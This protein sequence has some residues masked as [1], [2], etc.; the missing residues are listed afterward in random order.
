[1]LVLGG[2]RQREQRSL[3]EMPAPLGEVLGADIDEVLES[4]PL[5][6]YGRFMSLSEAELGRGPAWMMPGDPQWEE[7]LTPVVSQ[8]EALARLRSAGLEDHLDIPASGI[9]E[10]ALDILIERKKTE[11][12]RQSIW[13]RA[14][15]GLGPALARLAAGLGAS[16]LDPVNIGLGFVPVISG[17]RYAAWLAG[18]SAA[19]RFGVRAG[20]GVVEGAAGAALIEPM[21]MLSKAREQADYGL[22]ES[23]MNI[24]FGGL[25]GGGLH[26]IGG[27]AADAL[28]GPGI[29]APPGSMDRVMALMPLEAKQAIL[30]QAVGATVDGG[31][32]RTDAVLTALAEQDDRVRRVLEQE[33]IAAGYDRTLAEGP[34]GDPFEAIATIE[35]SELDRILLT[36][37]AAL[38]RD[39]EISVTGKTLQKAFG[40]ERGFGL[41]KILWRHGERSGKEPAFR[42]TK[43]DI[44]ALPDVI[45]DYEPLPGGNPRQR[46]WRVERNGRIVVYSASQ[47]NTRDNASRVTTIHIRDRA[48]PSPLSERKA[49]VAPG[50]SRELEWL[51]GD[52][53]TG[54]F[55]SSP[56]GP[57]AAPA[58][59]DIGASGRPRNQ[60][61]PAVA[62][63]TDEAKRLRALEVEPARSESLYSFIQRQGGVRPDDLEGQ[64]IK[65]VLAGRRR[66]P[67]GFFAKSGK[68]AD[69]LALAAWE[70]GYL[71]TP[72]GERPTLQE[73]YDALEREARGERVY[74]QGRAEEFMGLRAYR[75]SIEQALADVGLSLNDD[76]ARVGQALADLQR[77]AESAASRAA[78]EM[79]SGAYHSE[80]TDPDYL[81][82][83]TAAEETARRQPVTQEER[84][85]L[86]EQ[87]VADYEADLR[88][89]RDGGEL[90][91][92]SAAALAAADE[93]MAQAERVAAAARQGAA[94]MVRNG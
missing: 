49:G 90:D 20:V 92:E 65:A 37:G 52:T 26:S 11:L 24:T 43:E 39:G 22:F 48:E 38:E 34:H 57:G 28:R 70:A 27:A 56:E 68:N 58:R 55:Q 78:E 72:G 74:P 82:M 53:A 47:F 88:A 64:E 8:D 66:P 4:N 6:A 79:R 93:G 36:R 54:T 71:G 42:V 83:T 9:R 33:R 41:V 2:I 40:S 84:M 7:P 86:L 85:Q 23:F 30:A 76:P 3:Q 80:T 19:G 25:L 46:E 16:A 5:S 94:C 73:F 14:P 89:L 15:G 35:P 81:E 87:I 12:G 69:D 75:D 13:S 29:M 17:Q 67:P 77:Q 59:E 60:A 45:R 51:P 18:R 31:Q 1:M 21:I 50:S 62:F 91:A 10:G 44:T 63:W 32:V 61:D